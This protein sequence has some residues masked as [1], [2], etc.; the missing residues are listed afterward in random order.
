MLLHGRNAR[1]L[2]LTYLRIQLFPSIPKEGI[3]N[4]ILDP[5]YDVSCLLF[6]LIIKVGGRRSLLLELIINNFGVHVLIIT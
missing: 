4:I 2:I 5:R 3:R 1:F 6:L